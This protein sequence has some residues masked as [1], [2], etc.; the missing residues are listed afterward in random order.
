MGTVKIMAYLV[1]YTNH[2]F[3][4]KKLVFTEF[5]VMLRYREHFVHLNKALLAFEYVAL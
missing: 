4:K 5:G 2:I 3:K 1:H